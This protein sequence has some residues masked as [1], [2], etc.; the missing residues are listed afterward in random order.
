MQKAICDK[1]KHPLTKEQILKILREELPTLR[2]KYGVEQIAL[3]G[4]FAK[5]K[6][7]EESD[8]DLVIHLSKPIGFSFI[9]LVSYLESILGRKID[10][11]TYETLKHC[12]H[13]PKY[14]DIAKEIEEILVYV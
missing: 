11:I 6:A 9:S 5:G 12:K 8:I 4:S 3:F 2:E 14:K 1:E 7:T 10:I 13:M